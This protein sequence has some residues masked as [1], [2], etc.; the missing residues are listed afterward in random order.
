DILEVRYHGKNI[1]QILDLSVDQAVEF[2]SSQKEP[3]A[4]RVA[5]SLTVLQ[6]VGLGY[7]KLGQSCST[8]SGGESQRIMLAQFLSNDLKNRRQG[9]LFIFDEPTT[10]LHFHDVKKLLDAFNA[11]VDAGNT[12]VVVEHNTDVIKAA[13]WIIELGPDS[14]DMGGEVVYTG[15]PAC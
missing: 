14:G 5:E 2:F 15:T 12:I 13:D 7:V 6:R 8:L 1:D 11:L 3:A 9:K 10:G 4:A